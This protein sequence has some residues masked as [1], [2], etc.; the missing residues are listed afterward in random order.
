MDPEI[1]SHE[2]EAAPI[3]YAVAPIAAVEEEE[4]RE[5]RAGLYLASLFALAL[6]LLII[7]AITLPNNGPFTSATGDA[8]TGTGLDRLDVSGQEVETVDGAPVPVEVEGE[9]QQ[10]GEE[11]GSPE[12]VEVETGDAE[13]QVASASAQATDNGTDAATS[14]ALSLADDEPID[15]GANNTN[16][17]AETADGATGAIG[18]TVSGESGDSNANAAGTRNGDDNTGAPAVDSTT[19]TTTST[20]TTTA[21]PA[22]TTTAEAAAKETTTTAPTS[23]TSKTT[24]STTTTSTTTTT[25]TTT[26]APKVEPVE[27]SQRIDIGRIGDTTLQFRFTS[28]ATTGYTVT[29][30]SGS[31]VAKTL[32]GSANAGVLVNQTV[33]GLTPGTDYTVQVTLN[34]PPVATS[35]RV[36]FRTSGGE[37]EPIA[38]AVTLGGVEVVDVRA[39][40]FQVNYTSNICANGSFVIREQ[41]GGQVGSNSGQAAGCTTRHLAIPG[42]WTN[43]LK[44]NTVYVITI[45]VEA[46]GAG[47]GNGNKASRTLTVTTAS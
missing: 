20:T 11:S 27:F 42:F 13:Q 37:P 33:S 31:S 4:D 34:G 1:E 17:G 26:E 16:S 45:T 47:K 10:A 32:S 35:P 6:P 22:T 36:A 23:T 15:D 30:R 14:P 3:D 8:S 5:E 40:R 43:R 12:P 41:G 7:L 38:T 25:T 28:A 19:S 46:N 24:T 39:D 2:A 18:V 29:V 44:P 9:T 21:R